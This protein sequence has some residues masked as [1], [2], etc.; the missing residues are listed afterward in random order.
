MTRQDQ[1]MWF[2]NLL[3][4][5]AIGIAAFAIAAFIYYQIRNR[6]P[7][8]EKELTK[9]QMR[10]QARKAAKANRKVSSKERARQAN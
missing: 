5:L 1:A 10:R 7:R 2:I 3:R 8:K 9:K 6:L 4:I